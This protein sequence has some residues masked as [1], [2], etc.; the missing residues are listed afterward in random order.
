MMDYKNDSKE[1][2]IAGNS[3]ILY[4]RLFITMGISLYTSRVVLRVLGI[5][6]FGI[7]NVVAGF[8]AMFAVLSDSLSS[9]ISRFITI[10]LGEN[11]LEY[12]R[13]IYST[14]VNIQI[15]LTIII[16]L[17]AEL[18]GLWFINDKINVPLEREGILNTVFQLAIVTFAFGIIKV[19]FTAL[20]FAHERAKA[21]GW[22]TIIESLL[23]LLAILML[24]H[25]SYD[26]LVV[27][28]IYL[29]LIQ[30]AITIS[31]AVYCY[32]SFK[33]CRY[34]NVFEVSLIKEMFS[35]SGWSFLGRSAFV[36][37]NHSINILINYFFGV[38]VNAARGIAS[39]V[40]GATQQFV[41]NIMIA[42]NPQIIK[43][44]AVNDRAYMNKLICKGAKYGSFVVLLYS[45]PLLC[46]TNQIL[47]LWLGVVPS[48]TIVFT[49]LALITTLIYTMTLTLNTGI[50][51]T[52]NIRY[53]QIVT[54]V[55]M[56]SALPFSAL[57][58]Y[59]GGSPIYAYI[60]VLFINAIL[61]FVEV[62]I[63]KDKIGLSYIYF[64]KEAILRTII[65]GALSSILPIVLLNVLPSSIWRLIIIT[66][67]S[68]M[69][70][71]ISIMLVGITK[72][73]RMFIVKS[74]RA[75]FKNTYKRL[76]R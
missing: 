42:V 49:R 33:E 56:I 25:S 47:Q 9:S 54:S 26:K 13:K 38:G 55:L 35:F 64:F 4:L 72:S 28:V 73:E 58:F 74:I 70:T 30:I 67:L 32:K 66:L 50:Q 18:F 21:F 57:S 8:I 43:A 51:A 27:Y 16:V 7:Y 48:Y 5:D 59:L 61:V 2:R 63:V 76:S 39:Q 34:R 6:D 12:Q 71:T 19:A 52:G 1:K 40:D 36:I 45:I 10:A 44:Y 11:D 14:S 31:T 53:F 65:V 24:S 15:I 37:C 60:I 69:T 17:L 75:Y 3:I 62:L 22:L 41:T 68:L 29:L 46:E 23:K 20:I